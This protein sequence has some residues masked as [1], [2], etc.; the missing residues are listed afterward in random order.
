MSDPLVQ[1]R[2]DVASVLESVAK[3]GLPGPRD[4][5][6]AIDAIFSTLDLRDD[7]ESQDLHDM[8]EAH[9]VE[10]KAHA[11]TCVAAN[12]YI[13]HVASLFALRRDGDPLAARNVQHD[14]DALEAFQKLD[15]LG[16]ALRNAASGNFIQKTHD[17]E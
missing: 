2:D 6:T 7:G 1:K 5:D 14:D 8:I 16:K 17:G 13:S 3:D 15:A 10:R 4:L 11:E 12:A 9:Q